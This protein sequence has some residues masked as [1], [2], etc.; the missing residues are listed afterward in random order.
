MVD[1]A[2]VGKTVYTTRCNR[3]HGLKNTENYTEQQWTGI[4]KNMIPKARLNEDESKQV[5]AY[6][7]AN[8]KK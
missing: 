2:S 5:T 8:A 1:L 4:L 7:M 3:C 6:V